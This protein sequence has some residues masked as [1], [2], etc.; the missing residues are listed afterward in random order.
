MSQSPA[1]SDNATSEEVPHR[2]DHTDG[3]PL[4]DHPGAAARAEAA[5]G[6]RDSGGDGPPEDS[7][8]GGSTA[9]DVTG[10]TA[11]D[12]AGTDDA[13]SENDATSEDV[14]TSDET[15]ADAAPAAATAIKEKSTAEY[16]TAVRRLPDRLTFRITGASMI[17]VIIVTVC[18]SPLAMSSWWLA[19]LFLVPIAMA[20]S[21]L[22]VRTVV[23]PETVSACSLFRT[24][25][26]HWDDVKS[27][28]LD[29]RRWVRLILTS[30]REVTLPAVRVRNIPNLAAMS[31]G[32]IA[33]PTP[34]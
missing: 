27:L 3:E 4:T 22:R 25:T 33:D 14:G 17:A 9:E 6:D 28:R 13:T 31:G 19:P 16:E 1:D 7:A 8:S 2:Q 5:G 10:D 21:V 34:A 32:R 15:D 11:E 20:V 24:R 12:P 30:D 23:T 29:E 26:V 18:M